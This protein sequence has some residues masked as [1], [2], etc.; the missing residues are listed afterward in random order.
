F[1][2]AQVIIEDFMQTKRRELLSF[3]FLATIFVSSNGVMG[4]LRSFDRK[5]PA[6]IERTGLARR[7]KSIKITF[8]IMIVLTISI[9]LLILQSNFMTNYAPDFFQNQTLI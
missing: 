8:I 2:S 3:G 1:H 7:W 5:S 9:A 4:L 6:L